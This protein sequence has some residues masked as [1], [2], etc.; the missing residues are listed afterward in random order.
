[1]WSKMERVL[2][3]EAEISLPDEGEGCAKLGTLKGDKRRSP[4]WSPSCSYSHH[5]FLPALQST[6]SATKVEEGVYVS[7]RDQTDER[8]GLT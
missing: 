5:L 6:T 2:E 3:A 4:G 8:K 7:L 1:M